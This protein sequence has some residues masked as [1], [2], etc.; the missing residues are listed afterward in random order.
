[1]LTAAFVRYDD[2]RFHSADAKI[3]KVFSYEQNICHK[4]FLYICT[5]MLVQRHMIERGFMGHAYEA[6]RLAWRSRTY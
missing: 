6:N 1:M 2:S 5:M 3:K 4:N